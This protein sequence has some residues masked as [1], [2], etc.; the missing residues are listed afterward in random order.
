MNEV[1]VLRQLMVRK[2]HCLKQLA[3]LGGTD[4]SFMP[5]DALWE[6]TKHPTYSQQWS[7]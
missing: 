4:T 7:P 3:L 6:A 5:S 1:S 2:E